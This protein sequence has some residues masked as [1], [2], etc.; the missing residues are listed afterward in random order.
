MNVVSDTV[1]VGRV[2]VCVNPVPVLLT[3][4]NL[5]ALPDNVGILSKA[6]E[7]RSN[8]ARIEAEVAADPVDGH[9]PWL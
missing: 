4:T 1:A 5:L 9:A 6:A 3:R 2:A 7:R 8:S